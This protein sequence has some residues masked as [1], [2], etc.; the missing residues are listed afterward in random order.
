MSSP[1]H[2]VNQSC[3]HRIFLRLYS[4]ASEM[5]PSA[6]HVS[7]EP[8][9]NPSTLF[10]LVGDDCDKNPLSQF[11]RPLDI[12]FKFIGIP[13]IHRRHLAQTAKY[14]LIRLLGWLIFALNIGTNLLAMTMWSPGSS[15]SGNKILKTSSTITGTVLILTLNDLLY[16]WGGHLTLLLL[17]GGSR[18]LKLARTLQRL[19]GP[20]VQI[21]QF[22][23]IVLIIFLLVKLLFGYSAL[24]LPS[25]IL[26]I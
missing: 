25:Y 4:Q 12:V 17:S 9:E 15:S 5:P 24:Q 2:S 18:Q 23:K 7:P 22:S 21:R 16:K 8:G 19:S 11:L 13:L 14:K 6:D 20:S 26:L 1:S 3:A 10:D